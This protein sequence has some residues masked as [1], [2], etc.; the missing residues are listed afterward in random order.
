VEQIAAGKHHSLFL[1]DGNV[2]GCGAN[3][4]S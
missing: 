1:V 3:N 4:Y 2:W